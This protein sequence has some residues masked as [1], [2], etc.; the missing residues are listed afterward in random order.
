MFHGLEGPQAATM[1][2]TAGHADTGHRR[3][4]RL[5]YFDHGLL[6]AHRNG[7]S[8]WSRRISATKVYVPASRQ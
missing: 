5:R 1:G 2:E 6:C 4:C 8:S 3:T 7:E